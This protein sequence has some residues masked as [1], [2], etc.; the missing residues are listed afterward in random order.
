VAGDNSKRLCCVGQ[1]WRIGLPPFTVDPYFYVASELPSGLLQPA[2]DSYKGFVPDLISALSLIM[3]FDYSLIAIPV[4]PLEQTIVYLQNNS[5]H[6]DGA[7]KPIDAPM[8][9]RVALTMPLIEDRFGALVHRKVKARSLLSVFSPFSIHVWAAVIGSIF[10]FAMLIVALLML[11]PKTTCQG[12]WAQL[13][14]DRLAMASYHAWAAVLGGEDYEWRSAPGRMLR[15]A[16]LLL[17]LIISATYTANLAAFLV[18]PNVELLGPQDMQEL[19]NAR[20]C[21]PAAPF[22]DYVESFVGTLVQPPF[23]GG[24]EKRGEWCYHELI[25]DRVD[26]L[27]DSS[28]VN[29]KFSLNHCDDTAL[30]ST[31]NFSPIFLTLMFNKE[32]QSEAFVRNFTVAHAE[33]ARTRQFKNIEL[34]DL[35][36]GQKCPEKRYSATDPMQLD[37]MGG[38]F[39][40]SGSIA[41][42]AVLMAAYKKL[43]KTYSKAEKTRTGA[44]AS[45]YATDGEIVR[46]VL[47]ELR[48]LRTTVAS[49]DMSSGAGGGTTMEHS[50]TL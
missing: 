48:Q 26:A 50:V 21:L 4:H 25:A 22:E 19:A 31:I 28:E 7:L 39:L 33:F 30:V 41:G 49:R 24:G 23:T 13:K 5:D 35:G 27:V 6:I 9:D 3:G 32:P 46:Q 40:I 34:E 18:A 38:L 43:V 42:C 8:D 17:V 47:A 10:S 14:P 37:S 20:V 36:R 16:L 1:K 2:T 12:A 15:L 11:D 45:E 44:H 29:K